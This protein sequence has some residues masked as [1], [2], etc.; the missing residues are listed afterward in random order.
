MSILLRQ[1]IPAKLAQE[2]LAIPFVDARNFAQ[3]HGQ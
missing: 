3:N 2:Q 1:I